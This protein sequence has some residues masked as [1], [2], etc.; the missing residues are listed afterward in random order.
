VV[1]GLEDGS[2]VFDVQY[3]TFGDATAVDSRVLTVEGTVS[4][5]P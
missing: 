4:G 3:R 1:D 2:H 5:A